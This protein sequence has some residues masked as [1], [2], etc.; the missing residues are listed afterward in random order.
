MLLLT[1]IQIHLTR[2]IGRKIHN[3]GDYEIERYIHKNESNQLTIEAKCLNCNSEYLYLT[4]PVIIYIQFSFGCNSDKIKNVFS[5]R[6]VC[7]KC[8]KNNFDF[9]MV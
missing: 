8:K 7:E 3:L 2:R 1:H 4:V 9:I 5:E 6:I